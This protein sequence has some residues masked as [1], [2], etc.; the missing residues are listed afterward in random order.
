M[1][2]SRHTTPGIWGLQFYWT[3]KLI[4]WLVLLVLTL[5]LVL[6]NREHV[7][8]NVLFWDFHIRLVWVLLGVFLLGALLGWMVPRLRAGMRQRRSR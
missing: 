4:A 7:D 8:V 3:P 5:I 1:S 6:Q 2:R